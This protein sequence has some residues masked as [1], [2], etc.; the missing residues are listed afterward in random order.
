MDNKEDRAHINAWAATQNPKQDFD[1]LRRTSP[2]WVQKR[3]KC[4]IPPP[5]ILYTLVA[6]IFQIYGPLK[7]SVTGA[8]L[9]T[10]DNWP[11]TKNILDLIY[12]GFLSDAPGIPLYTVI[13]TDKKAGGLPI[14]HY[15]CGTNYTEGGVHTHL[16]S[17]L[18]SL[19]ASIRHICGRLLDFVVRHNLLVS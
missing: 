10:A 5:N 17:H 2:A 9:F 18:P 8:L 12:H 13:G 14:Y 3:C 16:H 7:D 15:A 4:I 11:I 1:Q 6:N 19:G